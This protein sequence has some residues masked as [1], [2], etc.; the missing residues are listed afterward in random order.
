[1]VV[2]R[3]WPVFHLDDEDGCYNEIESVFFENFLRGCVQHTNGGGVKSTVE[4]G[5][6]VAQS[7]NR[8]VKR[9]AVRFIHRKLKREASGRNGPF[10]GNGGFH[11]DVLDQ[12]ASVDDF[13][14]DGFNLAGNDT[15][16]VKC[17][18]DDA[19][20][21][22]DVAENIRREI[23]PGFGVAHP[24]GGVVVSGCKGLVRCVETHPHGGFVSGA[25]LD[26][27]R[28]FQNV[29]HFARV[30]RVEVN[31]KRRRSV[32]DVADD[33]GR[34]DGFTDGQIHGLTGGG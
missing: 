15:D 1:M 23:Q 31:A 25:D 30:G 21:L 17:G 29:V 27:G 20:L 11:D 26:H 10:A 6:V 12:V 8:H 14:I 13:I 22:A 2:H 7:G 24:D 4:H 19:V 5:L 34:G 18:H 9:T 33:D 16:V 28:R 32:A 3:R